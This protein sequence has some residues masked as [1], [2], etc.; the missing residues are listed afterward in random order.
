MDR[1]TELEIETFKPRVEEINIP[2]IPLTR[3]SPKLNTIQWQNIWIF[4]II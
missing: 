4:A 1:M 3:A 2:A